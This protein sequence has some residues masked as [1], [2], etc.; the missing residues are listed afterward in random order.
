MMDVLLAPADKKMRASAEWAGDADHWDAMRG[1]LLANDQLRRQMAAGR[2]FG[3]YREPPITFRPTY[4]LDAGTDNYDT[5]EKARA[6]CHRTRMSRAPPIA[7]QHLLSNTFLPS[8]Q[9]RVPAYTDRILYRARDDGDVA[10]ERYDSCSELKT[11]DHRPVLA[12]VRLRYAPSGTAG[13]TNQKARR[14]TA[15]MAFSVGAFT[16][17]SAPRRVGN[18][19]AAGGQRPP[20]G[21]ATSSVCSVM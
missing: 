15:R 6:P 19:W 8:A 3:P 1:V 4:R 12:E 11:S 18:G 20:A 17:P 13:V 5:S 14:A 21:G 16:E 2:A 10:I 9:A 7:P